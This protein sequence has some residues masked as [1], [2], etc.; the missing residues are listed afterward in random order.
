MWLFKRLPYDAQ[1]VLLHSWGPQSSVCD[2]GTSVWCAAPMMS[3]E[4]YLVTSSDFLC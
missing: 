1:A 2:L 3:E 4:L